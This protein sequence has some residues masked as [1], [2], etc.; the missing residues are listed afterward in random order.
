MKIKRIRIEHFRCWKDQTIEVGPYNCFVGT[1]GAGK[2]AVLCALNL[3]FRHSQ[4]SPTNV[5]HLHEEDFYRKDTTQPIRVTVTFDDL[6][7]EAQSDLKAY[8]R[9]GE[10]TVQSEAIWDEKTRTASSNHYGNRKVMRA[11]FPYFTAVEEN[12]LSAE[13]KEIYKQLKTTHELP[14]ATTKDAMLEALRAYEEARP[15][16]C[17]LAL[18]QN[19]FY[20][21]TKG[22]NYLEKYIQW[23]YVPAVKDASSEQDE[24]KN[25]AFGQLLERT[26]RQEVDFEPQLAALKKGAGDQYKQ[27]LEGN[28]G[29]LTGITDRLQSRLRVWSSP[30]SEIKLD[31][32]YD[33]RSVTVTAPSAHAQAGEDSFL[34]EVSRLGHGL[35]RSYLVAL[36]QE[37]AEQKGTETQPTL[38]LGFEEPELYQHPPQ[39]KYLRTVLEELAKQ[40]SQVLITTHSPHMVSSEGFVTLRRVTKERSDTPESKVSY[41]TVEQVSET[42]ATALGEAIPATSKTLAD[43]EQLMEPSLSELYFCDLAILVEGSEDVAYLSAHLAVTN[44]LDWF[45]RRGCHFVICRGKTNISRPL[46]IAQSL[47][48]PTYVVFDNDYTLTNAEA[49]MIRHTVASLLLGRGADLRNIQILLGHSA[50]FL[51]W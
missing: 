19:Q 27:L 1:N 31:W 44:Q 25:S 8:F 32:I 14:A 46:A 37:L 42:V 4:N 50:P 18:S 13:L 51:G 10:L 35:Q 9:Q 28:K 11:F 41:A 40:G 15:D 6:T 43:I 47:K 21:F 39:A 2:S 17:E 5:V 12:K 20:G 38:I 34:G 29:V 48:I 3:F 24:T 7:P 45:R 22:A 16:E 23:V 26:I 49:L 36:L 33:E 30:R